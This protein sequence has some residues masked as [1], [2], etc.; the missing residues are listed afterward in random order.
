MFTF[1]I[2]LITEKGR[3]IHAYAAVSKAAFEHVLLEPD[4]AAAF[5]FLATSAENFVD[6]HERQ[7]LS[8]EELEQNY[9]VFQAEIQAFEDAAQDTPA[10]R[11]AALNK[12]VETRIKQSR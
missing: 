3:G 1:L 11:L 10:N 12:L 7:P 2:D 8:S 9:K 6:Q 4:H 5:Y